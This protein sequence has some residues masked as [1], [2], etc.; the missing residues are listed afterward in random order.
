MVCKIRLLGPT[1]EF[2]SVDLGY[3]LE[4]AFVFPPYTTNIEYTLCA[5]LK[6]TTVIKRI[7]VCISE[8]L[9]SEVINIY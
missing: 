4:T 6:L 2:D 7:M 3:G 1:S 8:S 5:G 9:H